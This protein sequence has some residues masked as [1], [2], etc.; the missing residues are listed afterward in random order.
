VYQSKPLPV[1]ERTVAV[2]FWQYVIGE[3]TVGAAGVAFTVTVIEA[4]GP[5]QVPVD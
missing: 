1:A 5:S 4:R 2:A 3:V